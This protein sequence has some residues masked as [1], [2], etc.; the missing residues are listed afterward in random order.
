MPTN[1]PGCGTGAMNLGVR[2]LQLHWHREAMARSVQLKGQQ[3][4]IEMN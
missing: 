3:L 4:T 1:L 2:Q